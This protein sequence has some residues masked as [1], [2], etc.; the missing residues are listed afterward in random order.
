MAS[1]TSPNGKLCLVM[2]GS[3]ESEQ[4]PGQLE[5]RKTG[6]NPAIGSLDVDSYA[7]FPS[8]AAPD[9]TACFWAPDSKHFALMVRDSK[10]T[11]SVGIYEANGSMRKLPIPNLTEFALKTLGQNSTFRWSRE[12]PLRWSDATHIQIKLSGDYGTAPDVKEYSGEISISIMD[13]K[14]TLKEPFKTEKEEG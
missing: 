8:V 11:W 10:R 1:G 13:G 6:S 5:L 4:H 3:S 9:Q 7:L 12:M 2:V 14:I